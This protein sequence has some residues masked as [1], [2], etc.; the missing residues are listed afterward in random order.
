MK[1]NHDLRECVM[2]GKNTGIKMGDCR[3]FNDKRDV[4]LNPKGKCFAFD[5]NKPIDYILEK[6][7]GK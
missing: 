5:T 1:S 7:V 3:A 6:E 2:C 4:L